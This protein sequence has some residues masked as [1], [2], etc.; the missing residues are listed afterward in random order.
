MR[1]DLVHLLRLLAPT[2]VR[3]YLLECSRQLA[4]LA[5]SSLAM[6]FRALGRNH[7]ILELWVAIARFYCY[8]SSH[9][10]GLK[11]GTLE[12]A[13]P[14]ATDTNA[15]IAV[16]LCREMFRRRFSKSHWDTR[17]ARAVLQR[18]PEGTV[19][20]PQVSQCQTCAS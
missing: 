5:T 17:S 16:G 2:T 9:S 3:S 13:A 8:G 4:V 6:K 18:R 14:A 19:Q 20:F 15:K 7:H 12:R 1:H 10:P 11:S